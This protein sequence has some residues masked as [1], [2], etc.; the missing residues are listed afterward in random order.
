MELNITTPDGRK[1]IKIV[2]SI[3]EGSTG[4]KMTFD[5]M[6]EASAALI[7]LKGGLSPVPLPQHTAS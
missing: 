3:T 7:N 6:E 1:E 2:N 5:S 4:L